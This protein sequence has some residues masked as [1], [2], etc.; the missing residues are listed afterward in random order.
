MKEELKPKKT[1]FFI[2]Q[3][4]KKINERKNASLHEIHTQDNKN[5]FLLSNQSFR[6]KTGQTMKS[7]SSAKSRTVQYEL[8]EDEHLSMELKLKRM[9]G[10]PH[11]RV[12]WFSSFQIKRIGCFSFIFPVLKKWIK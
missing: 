4:Q 7:K 8:K 2:S 3:L 1:S 10:A 6:V 11:A 12:I 5:I 9:Y